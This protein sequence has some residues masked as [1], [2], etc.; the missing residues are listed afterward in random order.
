MFKKLIEDSDF[1]DSSG[2]LDHSAIRARISELTPEPEP[3]PEP[4]PSQSSGAS[5]SSSSGSS[6]S[7]SG[8]S[9]SS[10]SQPTGPSLDQYLPGTRALVEKLADLRGDG[11]QETFRS[12]LN[13]SSLVGGNGVLD[14]AAL[15][16]EVNRLTPAPEPEPE[17]EPSQSSGSSGS[18]SSGSGSSDSGSS[19]SGSGSQSVAAGSSSAAQIAVDFAVGKVNESGTH[20]VLGATGPKAWDCSSLMQAAFAQAGVSLPRTADQQFQGGQS[21]SLDN[22]QPGDIVFWVNGGRATHNAIYI[23]NGQVAHARNPQAGLSITSVYYA[24]QDPHPVA[25]RYW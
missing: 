15:Q 8:S 13:D 21:V 10:S 6:S 18:G 25:K 7:G 20:Y 5:D 16:R 19:S 17:P 14:H 24:F 9:S 1:T 22:L 3:E 11:V 2:L 12:A 4:E 23:G